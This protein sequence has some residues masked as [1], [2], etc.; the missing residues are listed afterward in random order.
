MA[1]GDLR[2][3]GAVPVLLMPFDERDEFDAESMR[4]Q[5]DFCVDA[6][7]DVLA[8]GWGTES[9]LMTDA[10]LVEAWSVVVEH[11]DGRVPVVAATTVAVCVMS[12]ATWRTVANPLF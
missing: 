10:E 8:F 2:I 12:S 11:T 1:A 7:S 6:G 3:A 9:H 5:V 4:R